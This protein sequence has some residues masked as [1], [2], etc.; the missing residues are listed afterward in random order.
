MFMVI[1]YNYVGYYSNFNIYENLK[2]DRNVI[3]SVV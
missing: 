1:A 2:T 3:T